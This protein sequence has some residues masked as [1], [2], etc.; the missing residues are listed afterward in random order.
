[1][2]ANARH[3]PHSLQFTGAD[4]GL[5]RLLLPAFNFFPCSL[6]CASVCLSP[7]H[8]LTSVIPD[9]SA[10]SDLR[11][12]FT[13]VASSGQRTLLPALVNS[14]WWARVRGLYN[15]KGVPRRWSHK[16]MYNKEREAALGSKDT[17]HKAAA[18][19]GREGGA[20]SS[21]SVR[22]PGCQRWPWGAI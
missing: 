8:C 2:R 12:A 3:W 10:L 17:E 21:S 19:G 11:M 16:L 7:F 14:G 5:D 4:E 22:A 9:Y 20:A 18:P 1:M 6:S 15:T 13:S